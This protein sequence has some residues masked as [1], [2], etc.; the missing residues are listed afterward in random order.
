MK[1]VF[2]FECMLLWPKKLIFFLV[3]IKS[4][5]TRSFASG[6]NKNICK[7]HKNITIE[8][9]LNG[10]SKKLVFANFM[11]SLIKLNFALFLLMTLYVSNSTVCW[12]GM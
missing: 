2:H 4:Q 12:C 11:C 6:K 10:S 5:C 3:R 8:V 9:C 1:I 7:R